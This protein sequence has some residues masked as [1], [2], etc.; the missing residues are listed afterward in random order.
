MSEE[1]YSIIFQ[2][3]TT[4]EANKLATE[5]QY[6]LD[7]TVNIKST[8]TKERID[9]QDAGTI[10]IAA[11]GTSAVTTLIKGLMNWLL[12]TQS[13]KITIKKNGEIIGENLTSKDIERILDHNK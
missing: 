9:T 13:R 10:L 2:D 12:K 1:T 7:Q 6:F 11:L 3:A 5:L 8:I 4:A